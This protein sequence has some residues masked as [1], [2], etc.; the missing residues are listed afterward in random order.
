MAVDYYLELNTKLSDKD[1]LKM[2]LNLE[3][4]FQIEDKTG[5]YS[6]GVVGGIQI[7]K[8]DEYYAKVHQ[9][10]M[11]ENFGF[12]PTISAWFRTDSYEN[13]EIGMRNG[14][15]AFM[16]ILQY[17]DSDAVM[18]MDSEFVKLTRLNGKLILDA[19][20]FHKGEDTIWSYK[21]ITF[22]DFEVKDLPK[23]E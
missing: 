4:F 15:K 2:I 14:L 3:S 21:D 12:T 1:I 10:I 20:S 7:Q 19:G 13:Y 11:Q 6:D 18:L 8:D 23:I 22:A 17:D 5:F 16:T 9:E